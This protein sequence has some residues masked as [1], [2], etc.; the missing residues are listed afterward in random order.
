MDYS[1]ANFIQTFALAGGFRKN[2][3]VS[4]SGQQIWEM[5]LESAT[6]WISSTVLTTRP[7]STRLL[8]HERFL[9][10]L[11]KSIAAL[12]SR[13]SCF[14]ERRCRSSLPF[15]HHGR[16]IKACGAACSE[17]RADTSHAET[18]V[19]AAGSVSSAVN[20]TAAHDRG[21]TS[22]WT[23]DSLAALPTARGK[24]A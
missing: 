17:A 12:L 21:N 16:R 20:L 24:E 18:L 19:P 6:S 7:L 14:H 5:K 11:L 3:E 23:H 22:I 15:L 8:F 1:R 4:R 9:V 10:A 2:H 13:K